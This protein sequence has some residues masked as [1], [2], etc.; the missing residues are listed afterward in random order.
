MAATT[1]IRQRHGNGCTQPA[2]GCKCPWQAEVWSPRDRKKIR[3]LFP[4]KG[5][6]KSWRDDASGQVRRKELRA[7]TPI[8]LDQAADAWLEGARTGL[9][10][11]RSGHPYKPSAIRS[12]EADLRLRVRPEFG[13]RKLAAITRTD[14]QDLADRL[15]A[16][17]LNA[18][19]IGGAILPLRVIYRRAVGRP[20]SGITVNPTTGLELPKPGGP[21]ERVADPD[22]CAR[23]LQALGASDRPLWATAMY[24]GLRRGELQALRVENID[25]EAGRHGMIDIIYGWDPIEG[26]I[27]TKNR[28]RRKVP[29]L[30]SLRP[31]LKPHLEGLPWGERPDGLVFGD[32]PRKPF[33]PSSNEQRAKR[34]W[35]WKQ[36][37][38]PEGGSPKKIRVPSRPDPLEPI[39]MHECRHT[40]V[41]L[42]IAA[43]VELYTIGQLI[44]DTVKMV[45][46]TY[47][48]LLK[49]AEQRAGEELDTYLDL[50]DTSARLAQLEPTGTMTG[51]SDT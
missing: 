33:A 1:G 8:T 43:K 20:D 3:K 17:G 36:V 44:G 51:T 15:H 39:G 48:H 29:I 10:R 9:I 5:A 12:I 50:A 14:L 25:L 22:E 18:T 34:A 26:E 35:G 16:E 23:L 31:Y 38:N 24:A 46:T 2:S 4:T 19:T 7:P 30:K 47:A 27:P 37:P 40:Y 21:R 13:W 41:A 6:A 11:T 45:E 49:G 28:R 42:L 32:Q